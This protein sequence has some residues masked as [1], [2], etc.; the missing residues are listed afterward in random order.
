MHRGCRR[1]SRLTVTQH[2]YAHLV[3][4]KRSYAAAASYRNSA[5]LVVPQRPELGISRSL[6]KALSPYSKENRSFE[7]FQTRTLPMW[8]EFFDS[9]LWSRLVLQLSHDQPAIKHGILALSVMH[10]R[11]ESVAPVSMAVG[12]D[13]AF[14]QYMQAVKHSNDLL[15]AYQSGKASLEMVLIACIIFT[16]YENLAGNY[17]IASM[18]LRSGLRILDQQHRAGSLLD[19]GRG[20]IANSL[21]RFDLEAMTFSDT[22]S[23]YDY[24]LD[25]APVCPKVPDKYTKNDAAR[26]DLVNILR[27]MMW[28]AGVADINPCAPE[29]SKWQ[30]IQKS[31]SLA[32]KKWQ[33]AFDDFKSHMPSRE[34]ADPKVYAGN[35][36]LTMAALTIHIIIHSGAGT[37]SEMAWDPFL[38]SFTSM[39][40]LAET[41]PILHAPT[42][43]PKYRTIA[44]KTASKTAPPP[45]HF[46]PSFELSPIVSL[47]ITACRCRDPSL[48]RRAI[49]LLLSYHRREGIWDSTGAG[50]IAA[51]CMLLEESLPLSSPFTARNPRVNSS[52][53]VPERRRV[54]DML[55]EVKERGGRVELVYTLITGEREEGVKVVYESW[56]G[57]GGL[58]FGGGMGMRA[59]THVGVKSLDR[60]V[61]RWM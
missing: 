51:Q 58:G 48:R 53:D 6:G 18:H 44:P 4:E 36:L 15:T 20:E 39:V 12:N 38:P 23:P 22:A 24:V 33:S 55:L 8:T 61:R 26:D 28:L 60:L 17:E 35:T 59:K 1:R 29:H 54:R 7:Y 21:Y 10:E 43:N 31:T 19:I 45:T 11:Y 56:R 41:I 46:S 27:S 49:A 5:F 52:A 40:D 47:F 34:T 42:T 32:I 30:Q 9:E 25:L 13:F 37:H 14:V 57:A 16:C 2:R 50:K 3:R